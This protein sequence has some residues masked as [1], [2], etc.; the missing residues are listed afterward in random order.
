MRNF[1]QSFVLFVSTLVIGANSAVWSQIDVT[2]SSGVD[3]T[4][5]DKMAVFELWTDYLNSS[6]GEIWADSVWDGD[7]IR[8]WRDFDLTAPF[9]YRND[10]DSFFSTYTPTVMAIEKE[11]T[12][13]SIRTLFYAEGLEPPS[14][15]QNLRAI[16]RVYAGNDEGQWKL[17][18]ALGVCTEDWNRPAIGKITFVSPPS[19]DFDVALARRSVAF[20]DSISDVFGFFQ[21][22]SFDFYITDSREEVDRVIGLEYYFAGFPWG[23]AMRQYDILITGRGTEWYPRGLVQMVATGSGLNPHPIVRDGIAGWLGGWQ[24]KT[25]AENMRDVAASVAAGEEVSFRT[26]VEQDRDIHAE[27]L[28]YFPGAVLCELVFDARGADGIE[29]L[30]KA[31]GSTGDLY[32]AIDSTLGFTRS[33]FEQAWRAKILEYR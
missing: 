20:C 15:N 29:A 33:A 2:L 32:R 11:G 26:Y 3:T 25:Y 12:K 8:F 23:R 24:Q 4:D 16:V 14:N 19:H 13:Y 28:L 5:V 21:W 30:F 22:D 10:A 7:K 17:R 9:V 27:G 18:N 6:P 1:L 31:G